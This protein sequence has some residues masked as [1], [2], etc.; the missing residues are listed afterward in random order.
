MMEMDDPVPTITRTH[1]EEAIVG[2]RI[3]VNDFDLERFEQFRKKM[4][5]SYKA[6]AGANSAPKI[7]WPEDNS[8]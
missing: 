7:N 4:D 3:S 5:P 6:G 1:F 8:N 2:A